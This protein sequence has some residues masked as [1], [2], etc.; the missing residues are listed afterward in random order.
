MI[1]LI[2]NEKANWDRNFILNNYS[3]NNPPPPCVGDVHP[4]GSGYVV[5]VHPDHGVL[6]HRQPGRL[7]HRREAGVTHRQE[8]GEHMD[9]NQW[10]TVPE[11]WAGLGFLLDLFKWLNSWLKKAA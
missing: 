11:Q 6:L 9:N 5:P 2:F 10:I 4:D 1:N 8:T 7:S 3:I